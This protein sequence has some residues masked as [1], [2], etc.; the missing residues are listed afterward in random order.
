[1]LF[2]AIV[3]RIAGQQLSWD[4]GVVLPLFIN[5]SEFAIVE[6]GPEEGDRTYYRNTG[7]WLGGLAEE[8]VIPIPILSVTYRID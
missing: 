6:G 3:F 7:Y 5:D 8:I 1:M 4:I 2:P